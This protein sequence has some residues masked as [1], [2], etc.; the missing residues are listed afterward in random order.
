MKA[1]MNMA[2]DYVTATI[3]RVVVTVLIGSFC[4]FILMASAIEW[5]IDL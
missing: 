4:A 2:L 3:P 5:L 1:F